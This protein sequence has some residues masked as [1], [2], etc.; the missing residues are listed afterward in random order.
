MLMAGANAMGCLVTLIMTTFVYL[1]VG[2]EA[3]S[4]VRLPRLQ[5]PTAMTESSASSA[6]AFLVAL[7]LSVQAI[8]SLT[9]DPARTVALGVHQPWGGA[10]GEDGAFTVC[11]SD[12]R[13]RRDMPWELCENSFESRAIGGVHH[14]K[15]QVHVYAIC[16]RKDRL[17][18]YLFDLR[19]WRLPVCGS[20]AVWVGLVTWCYLFAVSELVARRR[21]RKKRKKFKKN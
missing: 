6:A 18:G 4:G 9:A 13:L 10:C 8:Y 21:A 2:T 16:G 20:A 7:Y 17:G 1:Y 15:E 5:N 14:D 12:I 19:A 11:M 3:F